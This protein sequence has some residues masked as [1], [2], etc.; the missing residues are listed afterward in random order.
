MLCEHSY[1]QQCV[2]FF[3]S[4]ICEQLRVLCERGL[5]ITAKAQVRVVLV[6]PLGTAEGRGTKVVDP[7]PDFPG[8]KKRSANMPRCWLMHVPLVTRCDFK[9]SLS[10]YL[11][12]SGKYKVEL[13][14]RC[15]N[16]WKNKSHWRPHRIP[17][18][19]QPQCISF[20]LFLNHVLCYFSQKL[21]KQKTR[22]WQPAWVRIFFFI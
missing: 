19:W 13:S 12:L 7:D 11:Y 10:K 14:C 2:P 21:P 20:S 18:A 9:P 6:T 17:C 5:K 22:F 16:Y 4:R 1:W 8:R 3:A 15:K